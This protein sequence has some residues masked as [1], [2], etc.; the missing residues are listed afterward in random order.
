MSARLLI[1]EI[2]RQQNSFKFIQIML[3]NVSV[4]FLEPKVDF[5]HCMKKKKIFGEGEYYHEI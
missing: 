2:K 5:H 4:T 3:A 1:L